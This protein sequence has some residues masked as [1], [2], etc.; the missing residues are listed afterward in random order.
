MARSFR[1]FGGVAATVD[2]VEVDLVGP[3]PRLVLA[4]L[5]LEPGRTVSVDRIVEAVWGERAPAQVASSLRGYLSR[6]RRALEPGGAPVDDGASAIAWRDGGYVLRASRTDVDVFAFEDAVADAGARLRAGGA[7]EARGGFEAAL[8]LWDGG[9]LGRWAEELPVEDLVARLTARRGEALAGWFDA[10]LTLGEHEAVIADVAGAI[11]ED[12]L[13]EGLRA[14]HALALYRSGRQVEALRA[15]DDARR[16]LVE[17]VGVEP[18]PELRELEAAILAHDDSLAVPASRLASEPVS[19]PDGTLGALDRLLGREAEL[20]VLDAA[21][22]A[23]FAGR[24][25]AVVVNGEPGIGKTALVRRFA[26]LAAAAGAAVAWARCPES[27]T[28]APFRPLRAIADQLEAAGTGVALAAAFEAGQAED[29]PSVGRLRGQRVA[30]EALA[31]TRRPC[32]LVIDDA[33]WADAASLALLELMA[34]DLVGLP[35][36][37]VLAIRRSGASDPTP[38]VDCLAELARV[39]GW[40]SIELRG[41]G[42]GALE[43]WMAAR[44][45][46]VASASMA[47]FVHERTGGN[48]F[49]VQELV[50]LLESEGRLDEP[51]VARIGSMVPVAVQDV[52]RRRSSRL[53]ATSQPVLSA[54]AVVGRRFDLDVLA[55]VVDS[56]SDDVL[57][58]LAPAMA[59]GLLDVDGARPGRFA[60][61][62]ALVAEALAAEQSPVRRARLHAAAAQALER[63]RAGN[64]EPFLGE[65]AFHAFEGAAAGT[66]ASAVDHGEAAARVAMDASGFADAVSHLEHALTALDLSAPGDLA[67]RQRLLFRLGLARGRDGDMFGSRAALVEAAGVAE[68]L[69]DVAQMVAALSHVSAD[70]LWSTI[71]WGQV[72]ERATGLIERTLALLP[73]GDSVERA[74]LLAA[75]DAQRYNVRSAQRHDVDPSPGSSPSAEAVEM[76]GRLGDPLVLARVLVQRYWSIWRTSGIAERTTIADR[77]LDLVATQ[78]LPERFTPLAHLARF[79]TAFEVGDGQLADHH[80]RLARATADPVRTAAAWAY[81]LYGESSVLLVR[82]DFLA[83]RERADQVREA[84]LRSR[85]FTADFTRAGLVA[86]AQ[87][88]LGSLDGAIETVGVLGASVFAGP[89]SWFRAY[90]FAEDG[91]IDDARHHLRLFRGPVA[92]DWYRPSLLVTALHAAVT[93]GEIDL[94][95]DLSADL[96]RDAHVLACTGSGGMVFGP[97]ALALARG[98]HALGDDDAAHAHLRT[99]LAMADRLGAEPWRARGLRFRAQ[100]DGTPGDRTEA[101][102]IARRLGMEGLVAA[103]ERD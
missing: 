78:S 101:L 4:V 99:A 34:G 62:H 33:Q 12:P 96:E 14:R 15:I 80:L 87:F 49:F 53:P 39:P 47:E 57:D 76:A 65:L 59:A 83:A 64:L 46:R 7:A 81:V 22:T 88:E 95:R 51:D 40:Q 28:D 16:T 92:D 61:S 69:G 43:E 24:G 1:L 10:R 54:A 18:G 3:K 42:A 98:A 5:L 44:T 71:D 6:L 19:T 35:I 41:L 58:R 36:L 94:V 31:A 100:L 74:S 26:D 45:G 102:A 60:F 67:R 27:A 23:A 84:M 32:L 30:L 29:D 55:A 11:A 90:M 85:R 97:A 37:L 79:T 56:P 93:V 13:R 38:L 77:L 68:R 70:D 50:A 21:A 8:A 73:E 103:I 25:R 48:P 20:A 91:R 72:D 52:V 2:G 66:A 75:N 9:P 89:S 63:L 82:G 17:E 86:Q